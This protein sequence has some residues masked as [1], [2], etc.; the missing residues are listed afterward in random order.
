M[1]AHV[2]WGR[3]QR[4]KERERERQRKERL[5]CQHGCKSFSFG[6]YFFIILNYVGGA[7]HIHVNA[8]ANRDWKH[9]VPLEVQPQ[10]AVESPAVGDGN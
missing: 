2:G 1:C 9:R 7:G 6:D 8:G 5:Q 4:Q 10:G 3:K